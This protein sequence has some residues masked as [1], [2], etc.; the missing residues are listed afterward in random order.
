MQPL[1]CPEEDT[2]RFGSHFFRNIGIVF[3][4]R[5]FFLGGQ[6]DLS[7]EEAHTPVME[8]LQDTVPKPDEPHI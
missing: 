7:A 8:S 6:N 5:V 3:S 4:V 2:L 1:Q